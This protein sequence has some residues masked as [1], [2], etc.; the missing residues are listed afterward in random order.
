MKKYPLLFSL[1]SPVV[2]AETVIEH[3]TDPISFERH[4][5]AVKFEQNVVKNSQKPTAYQ[6]A[7]SFNQNV[8]QQINQAILAQD[9]QTLEPLLS[10]Y[11][12]NANFDPLLWHYAHAALAY[13]KK[14][15]HSAIF[16]YRQLLARNPNLV[17]PRFDLALILAEDQQFREAVREFSHI[18]AG[19]P[20]DLRQIAEQTQMQIAESE[21]WQPDFYL[22]YTQ[23][24][25][26]NN[27]S[28][29]PIVNVNGRIFRK[30]ADSLPQ[31]AKGVRYG[32]GL[33][34]LHNVKGN[35]FAGLTLNYSGI[36]YWDNRDY[37]EQ[38]VSVSPNYS[39][40]TA[41]YRLTFSPFIEQNWLGSSRYNYQ[42]GA[43]V[44]GLRYLNSQW[45]MS[46]SVTHLQKR[47]FDELTA[48]RYNSYQN[49]ISGGLQ[50]QAV[51]NWRFF[52]NLDGSR[53]IAREKAQTS[54]KWLVRVGAFYQGEKW[55]TQASLGFGKRYF[56][57]KH[58]LFGYKRQ[59]KEYQA[60]LSVW[61][62]TWHWRGIVPK[63]NFRY[64]KIDSNIADFYSRQNK[65]VFFT[66]EKLF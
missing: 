17:Y 39:Y 61:N 40:R 11:Q 32:L 36:Y 62:R 29:S 14:D 38:S 47:Y 48:S 65:E 22:Q 28:S 58:Y 20:P 50:W 55:A 45:L 18:Q 31:S 6:P 27:A 30:N 43:T 63:L 10:H 37:R 5:Q 60:N 42:F 66:L 12:Q 4:S 19:L 33:S 26:V 49:Q 34:K 3:N 1:F 57:D 41:A 46:G 25:N 16:H 7:Y 9:W 35:H 64:Q 24:D 54:N 56:A 23:T 15:H 44:S 51:K 52:A 8:E 59:D 53:E 2:W 21:R 13:A